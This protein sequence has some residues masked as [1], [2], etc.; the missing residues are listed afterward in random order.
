MYKYCEVDFAGGP[1]GA[2]QR[3]PQPLG[4]DPVLVPRSVRNQAAQK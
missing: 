1:E 4:T 2:A 3:D